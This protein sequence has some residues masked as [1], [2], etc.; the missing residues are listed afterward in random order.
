MEA[1]ASRSRLLL[2]EKDADLNQDT[3]LVG[4]NINVYVASV[5]PPA[6]SPVPMQKGMKSQTELAFP[7]WSGFAGFCF[8][9]SDLPES[10][11]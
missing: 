4:E 1:S 6:L 10:Y 5:Q 3:K 9:A 2:L 8:Y 11:F 7:H